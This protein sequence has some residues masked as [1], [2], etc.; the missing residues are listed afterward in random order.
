MDFGL[1]EE[2]RL[3]QDT[4]RGYLGEQVP[5]GRV[6][7]L[8]EAKPDARHG[9]WG[10]LA[11]LGIAGIL[12]PEAHGG[13]G[14]A[15]L[16][17]ALAA[18]ELGAAVTPTPFLGSAVLAPVALL[19]AGSPAQRAEWLPRLAT[20]TLR[21]GGALSEQVGRREGARVTRVGDRLSGK[22]LL[23]LDTPGAEML[24]VGCED[25]AL[26]LVAVDAPGVEVEALATIDRTRCC[27]E[28]RFD[29]AAIAERLEGGDPSVTAERVLDAGRAVLAAD[30][31]GACQSMLDQAVAYARQRRQFGREVASFQAVKHLCAEMV[32]ELEPARSLCW[33][34]AHVFAAAPDAAPL[35]VA[36]AKSHLAEIAAQIAD[37]ATQVHGGIGYTDEQNLHLWFKRIGLNRQLLGGPAWLRERAARLQGLGLAPR[38]AV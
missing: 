33:Y 28:V 30:T 20:G 24:L 37:L 10:E 38:G 12:I 25:G 15:L 9:L 35:A 21:V 11:A 2:Q 13:S 1:S 32:A 27:A 7:E 23:A 4:L 36:L 3:L 5:V 31:L 18:E 16:D 22:T 6:R 26:A 19:E 29:G 14:L 34:A 17:A 8:A